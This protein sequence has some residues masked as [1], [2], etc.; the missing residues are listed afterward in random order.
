MPIGATVS[1][2]DEMKDVF[3]FQSTNSA[4]GPGLF[5]QLQD[6]LNAFTTEISDTFTIW[7][8]GSFVTLKPDPNDVDV[9]IFLDHATYNVVQAK[10]D[11]FKYKRFFPGIDCYIERV[12]PIDHV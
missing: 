10:L 9:V 7:I 5:I 11:V 2:L 4:T 1:T 3:V 8:D 12:Y 6:L